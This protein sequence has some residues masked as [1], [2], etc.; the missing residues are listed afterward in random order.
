MICSVTVAVFYRDVC[1]DMRSRLTGCVPKGAVHIPMDSKDLVFIC[2]Y[3]GTACSDG[4]DFYG[5]ISV[6]KMCAVLRGVGVKQDVRIND[7]AVK[8]L[9][10]I[11]Y[12]KD[13][14]TAF[15]TDVN[16]ETGCHGVITMSVRH[17]VSSYT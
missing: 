8:V 7:E 10:R 9:D 16:V 17:V 4:K 12:L 3:D 13:G 2:S 5:S 11:S 6:L 1:G 14:N 15:I